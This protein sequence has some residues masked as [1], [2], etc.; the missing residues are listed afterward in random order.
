MT[1]YH[2]FLCVFFLRDRLLRLQSVRLDIL[3]QLGMQRPPQIDSDEKHEA[4]NKLRHERPDVFT[5]VEKQHP[6]IFSS[7]V[8]HRER[9]CM[10]SNCKYQIQTNR[11]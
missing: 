3:N 7:H 5:S 4:L 11:W 2:P 1:D 10:L 8:I 6:G 9:K